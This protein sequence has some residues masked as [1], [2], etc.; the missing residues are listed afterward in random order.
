MHIRL[1][2]LLS[3]YPDFTRILV[4]FKYS[5]TKVNLPPDYFTLGLSEGAYWNL[6]LGLKYAFNIVVTILLL[7]IA[8]FLFTLGIILFEVFFY[9]PYNMISTCCA[10]V[11]QVA[12]K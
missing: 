1:K 4:I 7:S 12:P 8:I 9:Y 3:D 6:F 5:G 10:P 2:V 11:H